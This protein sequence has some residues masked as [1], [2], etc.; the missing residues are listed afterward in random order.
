MIFGFPMSITIVIAVIIAVVVFIVVVFTVI[1][2]AG[3]I[4]RPIMMLMTVSA[5]KYTARQR[6]KNRK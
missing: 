5:I 1:R 3:V 2:V 4:L 6:Q